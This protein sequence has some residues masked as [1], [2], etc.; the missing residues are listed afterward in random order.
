MVLSELNFEDSSE[1]EIAFLVH[2]S[3][4]LYVLSTFEINVLGRIK[5]TV[6]LVLSIAIRIEI[7]AD[8][9]EIISISNGIDHADQLISVA[10]DSTGNSV[11][12]F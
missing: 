10:K 6:Y 11:E 9:V 5:G 4:S 12:H 7:M 2:S 1:L 3:G 8:Q